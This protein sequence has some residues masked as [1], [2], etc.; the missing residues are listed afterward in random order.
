MTKKN[1]PFYYLKEAIL[2]LSK[3]SIQTN[4]VTFTKWIKN[5]NLGEKVGGKWIIDPEVLKNFMKE[6]FHIGKI[7]E[8]KK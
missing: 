3:N 4:K 2:V 5:Y 7:Y 1:K 8:K 6:N